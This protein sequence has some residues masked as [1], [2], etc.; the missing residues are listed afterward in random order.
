MLMRQQ[1]G[2]QN[3]KNH[4]IL[5]YELHIN[6]ILCKTRDASGLLIHINNNISIVCCGWI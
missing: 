4:N 1:H 6:D 2:D 3:I 5:C